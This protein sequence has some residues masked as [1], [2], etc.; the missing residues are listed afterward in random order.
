MAVVQ[1]MQSD[2]T[3]NVTTENGNEYT[4][5]IMEDFFSGHFSIDIFDEK[6]EIVEDEEIIL[7]ISNLIESKRD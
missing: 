5:L 6:E 7:E 4:V 1:L 2:L 3:Y